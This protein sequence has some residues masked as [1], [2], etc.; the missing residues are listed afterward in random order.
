[1]S[2]PWGVENPRDSLFGKASAAIAPVLAP[3]EFGDWETAGALV[4]GFVAKE[5][6]V[7][8][9]N[10]IYVGGAEEEE[11]EEPTTF[12]Q[13]LG[14]IATGFWNATVDTVKMTVSI[15]PG[16]NLVGEEEEEAALT[17]A[18][19]GAFTPLS[20]LAFTVFVLLY[21]P[22][23]VAVATQRQEY[24]IKWTAFSAA[25]LTGLGWV[26]RDPHLSGWTTAR[27]LRMLMH[28]LSQIADGNTLSRS[29]LSRRLK[30]S[31]EL[32]EQMLLDLCGSATSSPSMTRVPR[33]RVSVLTAHSAASAPP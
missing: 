8:T 29:E 6:V 33:V 3:A 7:G 18:L 11:A 24:G 16:V 10:Q 23:M 15:I 13:D 19:Q 4:T 5:V 25:Y 30:I 26:V 20:A 12:L 1:M 31:N 27:V 22:C 17:T 2:I 14:G 28:L 21:I 32:L 9:M